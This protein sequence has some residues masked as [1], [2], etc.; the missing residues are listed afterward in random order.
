MGELEIISGDAISEKERFSRIE[1]LKKLSYK[2]EHLPREEILKQYSN[3]VQKIEKGHF[4]WGSK[5]DLRAFEHQLIYSISVDSK[6]DKKTVKPSQSKVKED[7]RRYCL[8]YNKGTCPIDKSHE[9]KL[10]GVMVFKLHVCRKCL[11]QEGLELKH[12]EKDCN[13][14]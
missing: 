9:G 7:K 14:K 5:S 1:V 2:L 4:K 8:E 11:L 13:R 6:R 10:H 12:T 3:F